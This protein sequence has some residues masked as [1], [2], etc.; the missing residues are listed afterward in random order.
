MR[1]RRFDTLFLRLFVLM[2]VTL[3]VSHFVAY[4]S[5]T[6]GMPPPGQ[7]GRFDLQRL[8]TLPS[9]P[10]GSPFTQPPTPSGSPPDARPGPPPWSPPP[11]RELPTAALWLDYGVRMLVIALGAALGARWLSAPMR[12]LAR[13]SEDL[14][15]QLARPTPTVPVLDEQRG[16]VEVR[17]MARVFNQMATRIRAQ[18]D[19]RGLH[20]AAVSH[21]LRTPL[22]RLRMRLEHLTDKVAR[23]AVAD[24]HEMDALIDT[25]LTVLR[26]QQGASPAQP[27][28][29]AALLQ[30][31]AD[32]STEQGAP[33]SVEVPASLKV[34]AHPAALKRALGNLVSNALRHGGSA[35]L[36]ATRN[37]T[38]VLVHI[39]DNGPGIPPDRIERVFAPWVQLGDGGSRGGFGHG[40]GLAI[41]RDLIERDAGTVTLANR[42]DGGLRATVALPLP[43]PSGA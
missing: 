30:A 27:V 34:R 28:D 41:A 4:L 42:T 19:A 18:F 36:V 3:V 35:H 20:M 37:E 29:L 40:L 33:V 32:D 1:I 13:A 38:H 22:T 24:V 10:P 26:E 12:R 23:D 31:L 14:A 17:A 2:W 16:T 21:D 39:D 43:S 5:V 9:L 6:P 8:P 15:D 25:T 7:P 11:G